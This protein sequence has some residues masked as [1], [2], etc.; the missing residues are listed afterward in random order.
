MTEYNHIW[1]NNST[2]TL[3]KKF[4]VVAQG[5]DDGTPEK[6][7]S[8]E[9]T[10]GGGLNLSV[11]AIYTTWSPIIRVRHTETETDYGTLDELMTFYSYINPN[12]TPTNKLTFT[13]H[14]GVDHSV[15]IV[16]SFKKAIMG[17]HI[18]GDQAWYTVALRFIEVP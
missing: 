1:L 9:R 12:G 7:E 17:F 2:T 3:H 10:I 5:Y 13:D 16:G 14:H 18:E 4:R 8:L 11:G 6:A 15:Y